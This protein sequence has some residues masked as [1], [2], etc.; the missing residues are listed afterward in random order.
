VKSERCL[1]IAG[2]FRNLRVYQLVRAATG[3]I[4][5]IVKTFPREERFALTDEIRRSARSTKA[6]IS[7]AWARRRCKAVFINKIDEALGEA[8]ETRS[9]LADALDCAYLNA[10]Q[11]EKME[12]DWLSIASMLARRIDRAR[13]FCKFA[14]DADHRTIRGPMDDP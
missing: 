8:N 14:S 9:W 12:Q 13:D 10:E 3:E 7:E 11:F 2:S 4:F 1:P 5:S 6:M